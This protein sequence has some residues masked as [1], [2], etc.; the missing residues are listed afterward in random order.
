M[1][2][3]GTLLILAKVLTGKNVSENNHLFCVKWCVCL[4]HLHFAP[5]NPEDGEMYI[6]V[7]AHPGCPDKVQRA[8]KWLC[9]G[10]ELHLGY[11]TDDPNFI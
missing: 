10:V 6:L 2:L 9:V 7:P 5:E 4:C 11:K 3:Y 8:V 1:A